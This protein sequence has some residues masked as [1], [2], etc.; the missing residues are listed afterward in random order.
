MAKHYAFS[1][2]PS[3]SSIQAFR[4]FAKAGSAQEPF[5]GFGDPL[6]G[7]TGGTTRGK[8]TKLDIAKV[9][10]NLVVQANAKAPTPAQATEIA[11]VEAIRGAPRLPETADE[12]RAMAKALKSDPKSLWLQE[13]ATETTIKRLD[14]SK[15]RTLA[16]ATHGVMA[17]EVKGI[18]E[19]GSILTPPGKGRW[20][21][22]VIFGE[23][24]AKLKLTPTGCCCQPAIPPPP[25]VR[26]GAEGLSGLAKAFYAGSAPCWCRTG[27]SPRSHGAAYHS[28][29]ERIRSPSRPGQGRGASQ[30]DAGADR[31]AE[32]LGIR[33]SAVL[34]AVRVVGEF[35]CA[36]HFIDC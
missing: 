35:G 25:M 34:G 4:Q 16:F 6:I 32:P 29:V 5:A 17:G 14:L 30:G 2:L 20:R 1:V 9:F 23:E 3:V 22:T 11:D 36:D 19:S 31:H 24:I 28:H 26:R 21:T 12:L 8:R 15:Y 7:E 27:R 33:P 13:N 10:R 18:G